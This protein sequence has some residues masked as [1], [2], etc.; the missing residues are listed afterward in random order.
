LSAGQPA[1]APQ[2]SPLT[3][4][5]VWALWQQAA[6]GQPALALISGEAGI[7]KTRLAEELLA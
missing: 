2:P 4:A 5:L 3:G 6:H 1:S 7:G